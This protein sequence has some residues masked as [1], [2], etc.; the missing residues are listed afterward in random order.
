MQSPNAAGS[1]SDGDSDDPGWCSFFFLIS[2]LKCLSS[3]EQH[4]MSQLPPVLLLQRRKWS[5]PSK[6]SQT[7]FRCPVHFHPIP[8]SLL[9]SAS[10]A[11][12]EL[13]FSHPTLSLREA[14]A[15]LLPSRRLSLSALLISSRR[16]C[17]HGVRRSC[18]GPAAACQLSSKA[19]P[20][21]AHPKSSFLAQGSTNSSF[22][23]CSVTP[24]QVHA[25]AVSLVVP[26]LLAL[27][28]H[29]A[30]AA[31]ALRVMFAASPAAVAA[32]DV[33]RSVDALLLQLPPVMF[34]SSASIETQIGIISQ[35]RSIICT[36][37]SSCEELGN[38]GGAVACNSFIILGGVRSLIA[39]LKSDMCANKVP[40][41]CSPP[42]C[43][44]PFGKLIFLI[45]TDGRSKNIR[46][47]RALHQQ[48]QR[49]QCCSL[50]STRPLCSRT[51]SFRRPTSRRKRAGAPRSL[52]DVTV[53]QHLSQVVC[54]LAVIALFKNASGAILQILLRSHAL[55]PIMRAC[56]EYPM[57]LHVVSC[58]G[59]FQCSDLSYKL[60]R[61][62]LQF[63]PVAHR[64]SL[65][66]APSQS[67]PASCRPL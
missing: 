51:L 14:I 4:T 18:S 58:A 11:V 59:A 25:A 53:T 12:I 62:P 66:A 42:R 27:S 13:L 36:K 8:H 26:Q 37:R 23:G 57:L 16:C 21:C 40:I 5:G 6:R 63:L 30:E 41:A 56:V 54:V 45:P 61:H 65:T 33:F 20:T 31:A 46:E 39:C 52:I 64:F 10:K 29:H 55:A 28:D 9:L 34:A 50:P 3:Q 19:P 1:D 67:S 43:F 38:I 47:P 49:V 60:T 22:F 24:G 7:S 2:L 48:W 32:R 15:T 35:L 17:S 44:N